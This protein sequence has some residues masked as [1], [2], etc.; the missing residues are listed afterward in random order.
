MSQL[1]T[2]SEVV[3]G[4]SVIARIKD[5]RDEHPEATAYTVTEESAAGE[6]LLML[7]D[8]LRAS[9]DGRPKHERKEVIRIERLYRRARAEGRA[10]HYLATLTDDEE[11]VIFGLKLTVPA[12]LVRQ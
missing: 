6:L 5:Y 11:L 8:Q 2:S 7:A 3:P 10:L 1:E 12:I 9:L 4:G